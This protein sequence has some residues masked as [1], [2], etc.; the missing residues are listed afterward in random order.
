[1]LLL[2]GGACG[3]NAGRQRLGCSSNYFGLEPCDLRRWLSC[4][5]DGSELR[6]RHW[7]DGEGT[8]WLLLLLLLLGTVACRDPDSLR[9]CGADRDGKSCWVVVDGLRMSRHGHWYGV[10]RRRRHGHGAKVLEVLRVGTSSSVVLREG[11]G[12]PIALRHER[13]LHQSPGRRRRRGFGRAWTFSLLPFRLAVGGRASDRGASASAFTVS[14]WHAG[15]R[16]LFLFRR[17][18]ATR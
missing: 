4:D 12:G 16:S 6:M 13:R 14:L 1:M 7:D 18:R 10:G 11:L 9:S 5:D 3:D 8:R 15:L 2:C 17:R